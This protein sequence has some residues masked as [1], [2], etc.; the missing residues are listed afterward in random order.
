MTESECRRPEFV[1]GIPVVL[2]DGQTWHL[3]PV[4]VRVFA[5]FAGGRAVGT[6]IVTDPELDELRQ[7]YEDAAGWPKWLG[8]LSLAARLLLRNYELG[9]E[10]LGE[11]LAEVEGA[12]WP[13][14]V[15][16]LVYGSLESESAGDPPAVHGQEV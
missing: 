3:P 7:A 12:T 1:G 16:D 9:D 15:V 13:Q 14:T 8:L 5:R 11:L 4:G 10:D 6:R 2:A